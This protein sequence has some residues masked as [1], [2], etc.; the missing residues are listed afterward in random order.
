[1][2][3]KFVKK[4]AKKSVNGTISIKLFRKVLVIIVNPFGNFDTAAK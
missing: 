3:Y 4:R 1:M 2:Y